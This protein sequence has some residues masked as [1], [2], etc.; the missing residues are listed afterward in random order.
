MNKKAKIN[1][2]SCLFLFSIVFTA[3]SQSYPG[4]RVNG[5]YLYD[6]CGEKVILRGV[7]KMIIWQ[8]I[9][10]I[11]SFSEIAQ[12]GANAVR[13]VWT[14]SGSSGELDTAITNCIG[15]DMFPM[16]ELHDATGDIGGLQRCVDYWVRSDVVSV[17]QRHEEYLLVNIA[18]ECGDAD[19][20]NADF[21]NGYTDAISRMRNAGIHVPLVIDGTDWGKDINMLQAEGPGLI[22]ADPDHNLIFSIHMW[23]PGMWGYSAQTVR[24]EI[25]QSVSMNLPLIVGEFGNEW[26]QNAEGQIP[27]LTILEECQNNEI[28]WLAW[29]WGPGNDPQFWLDMTSDGTYNG[30][31]GWGREVA[32]T[33]R[34][35]IANTSVKSEYLRERTCGSGGDLLG[36]V[37]GSGSIDI[38]DALLIAQYY[39]GLNPQGFNTDAADVNSSGTIDIVDALLVAQYYVGLITSF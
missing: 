4:F 20:S 14:I 19:V 36:D 28:G 6:K 33:D 31:Q 7:N 17:I 37:N 29:S 18:N 22:D 9:D 34:N 38:V 3:M 32:V 12:T 35:S 24:D 39:V 30:L 26:E 11:P 13:I 2:L 16:V 21:R 27:Y 23:W 5:R 1:L 10:G 15:Q 25:A 8:D